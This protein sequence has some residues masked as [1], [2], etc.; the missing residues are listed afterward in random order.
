MLTADSKRIYWIDQLR[1]LAFLLVIAGHVELPSYINTYIYSFHMPLFFFVS[2]MT[3]NPEKILRT[4]MKDIVINK[5]KRLIIPYFWMNFMTLPLW[6]FTNKVLSHNPRRVSEVILGIFYGHGEKY[7]TPSNALWFLLTLFFADL[8]IAALLKFFKGNSTHMGMAV[9]LC[10][11]IGYLDR[12]RLRI[13]HTNTTFTAVVFIMLGYMFIYRY[14]KAPQTIDSMPCR[15]YFIT[16]ATLFLTGLF[17]AFL[18]KR[19]SMYKNNFGRALWL[20]YIAAIATTLAVTLV[21]MKLPKLRIIS[22]IGVNTMLYLGIHAPITRVF[23]RLFPTQMKQALYTVP[24]VI[25]LYFSLALLCPLFN[26]FFPFVVGKT[27]PYENL[28]GIFISGMLMTAFC[29]FIPFFNAA[30]FYFP[31]AF[32]VTANILIAAAV[33]LILSVFISVFGY[34]YLKIAYLINDPR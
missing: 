17:A 20:F 26:K 28:K 15:K 25:L 5:F 6:T 21:V 13:W 4:P 33:W 31:G 2:G 30:D 19:M 1:A 23:E 3:L 8:L 18:N 9:G 16:V 12:N 7:T 32:A 14:K 29:L 22:Y 34:K 10:A 11:I 24:F 27:T